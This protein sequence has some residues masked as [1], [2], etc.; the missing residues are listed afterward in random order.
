[1]RPLSWRRRVCGVAAI[2]GAALVFAAAASATIAAEMLS[3]YAGQ[4]NREI[5]SLSSEDVDDLVNGRGMGL[6]KAAELNSYPGPRHVLDMASELQLTQQQQNEITAI[7]DRM[8]VAAKP[9]GTEILVRERQLDQ[10]FARGEIV[11]SQLVAETEELGILKGRLRAVHLGAHLETRALLTQAQIA[12]YDE[13]RGYG[14][15]GDAAAHDHMHPG[16]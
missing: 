14:S 9:L 7:F 13:L 2:A 15:R 8:S 6:A 3:P 4:Q 16:N 10:Q 1:M 11:R 5:K 12:R